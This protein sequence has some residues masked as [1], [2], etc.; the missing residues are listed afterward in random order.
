[1]V[2]AWGIVSSLINQWLGRGDSEYAFINRDGEVVIEQFHSSAEYT[3]HRTVDG[4]TLTDRKKTRSG[5]A[6]GLP[7]P[8]PEHHFPQPLPWSQRIK[9]IS[10]SQSPPTQW[11][12]ITNGMPDGRAYLMGYDQLSKQVVGYLGTAG[13]S[14]EPPTAS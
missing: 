2:F 9:S 3:S 5:S 6:S 10:D 1:W 8:H 11:Y 14:S 13:F 7:L 12:L 4:Q